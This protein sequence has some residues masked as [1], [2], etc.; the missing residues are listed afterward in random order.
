MPP[1]TVTSRD[2]CLIDHKSTTNAHNWTDLR[3]WVEAPCGM[4]FRIITMTADIS[5]LLDE[6]VRVLRNPAKLAN[7]TKEE[8][9]Q[10]S[11]RNALILRINK[12]LVD[13]GLATMLPISTIH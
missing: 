6:Q 2:I 3:D 5:I 10:Y 11:Q 8:V 9:F 12:E 1:S 13:A 4:D 7:M